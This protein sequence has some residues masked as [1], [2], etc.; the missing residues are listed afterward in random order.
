MSVWR[1]TTLMLMAFCLAGIIPLGIIAHATNSL[2][3]TLTLPTG[4]PSFAG[5][6]A[7]PTPTDVPDWR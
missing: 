4:L 3:L 7:A 2:N 5:I 1:A 6:G